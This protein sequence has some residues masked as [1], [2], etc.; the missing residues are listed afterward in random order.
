MIDQ[1]TVIDVEHFN[2]DNYNQLKNIMKITTSIIFSSKF[3]MNEKQKDIF[4]SYKFKS[5]TNLNLSGQDVDD[6]FIKQLCVDGNLKKIM[7]INLSKTNVTHDLLEYLLEN[8]NVKCEGDK[9]A[10]SGTYGCPIVSIEI[11]ARDTKIT[12]NKH[13]FSLTNFGHTFFSY[14]WDTAYDTIKELNIIC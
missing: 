14:Y 1:I 12:N 5:L 7:R 10:I 3:K 13:F 2:S 11:D 8:E 9:V 4:L 6:E